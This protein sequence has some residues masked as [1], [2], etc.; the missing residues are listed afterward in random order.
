M[1][2]AFEGNKAE[3]KTMLPVIE[4]FTAARTLR[5]VDQILERAIRQ[6]QARDKVR[7]NVRGGTSAPVELRNPFVSILSASGVR[8]E[9]TSDLMGHSVTS[10]TETVYRHEIRPALTT[11]ATAMN[12]ILS[13]KPPA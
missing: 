8:I 11:G 12:K 4:L 3:T 7:R 9:D 10:V 5:M 2:S 1:V 13:K 6:A